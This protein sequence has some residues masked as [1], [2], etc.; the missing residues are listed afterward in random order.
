MEA[1]RELADRH[2]DE[3]KEMRN[4]L[5]GCKDAGRGPGDACLSAKLAGGIGP[6]SLIINKPRELVVARLESLLSTV[7]VDTPVT[8]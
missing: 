2:F 8:N 5:A 4:A 7:S 3:S 6:V 1:P